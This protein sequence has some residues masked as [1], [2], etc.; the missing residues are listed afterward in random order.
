[1]QP[2][3]MSNDGSHIARDTLLRRLLVSL[4][5]W[6]E[7]VT[8]LVRA[9]TFWLAVGLPWLLLALVFAGYV[10]SAPVRF[11]GLSAVTVFCGFVG[12]THGS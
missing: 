11:A 4:T 1:M 9:V 12:R 3:C 2:G 5:R 7:R 6:C 10:T 8:A